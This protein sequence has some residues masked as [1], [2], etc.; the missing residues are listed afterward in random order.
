MALIDFRSSS[1]C[2]I[3][4]VVQTKDSFRAGP[5]GAYI[6]IINKSSWYQKSSSCARNLQKLDLS[7]P[8]FSNVCTYEVCTS[9]VFHCM[10]AGVCCGPVNQANGRLKLEEFCYDSLHNEPA[11]AGLADGMVTLGEAGYIP[12]LIGT[13][14]SSSGSLGFLVC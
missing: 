13:S 12:Q 8:K 11:S 4:V 5:T 2:S 9:Y 3:Q 10:W 7:S 1:E 14:A 6:T